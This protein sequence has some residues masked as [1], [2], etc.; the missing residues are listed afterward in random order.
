MCCNNFLTFQGED[1]NN[2]EIVKKNQ[3]VNSKD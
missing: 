2:I 3:K 1:N